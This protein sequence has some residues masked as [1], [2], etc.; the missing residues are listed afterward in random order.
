M[1]MEM[2]RTM[3]VRDLARERSY[4]CVWAPSLRGPTYLFSPW[5][6]DVVGGGKLF[7]EGVDRLDRTGDV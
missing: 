2:S 1:A 6:A 3:M 7:R 4:Q 5:R